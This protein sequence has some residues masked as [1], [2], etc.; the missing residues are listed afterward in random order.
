MSVSELESFSRRDVARRAAET[1]EGRKKIEDMVTWIKELRQIV[2]D[3]PE[4]AKNYRPPRELLAEFYEQLA[5]EYEEIPLTKEEIEREFSAENLSKLPLNDYVKLLRR[6]PARF[7]THVTRQGI[8]DHVSHHYS[9]SEQYSGGFEKIIEAGKLQSVL[10]QYLQGVVTRDVVKQVLSDHLKIPQDFDT[11]EEAREHIDDFLNRSRSNMLVSSEIADQ[12]ALHV[13]MDHVADDFYGG[14]RGNEIFFAY[15]TA[16]VAAHNY[17]APQKTAFRKGLELNAEERSSEYNDFWIRNKKNGA[18]ELPVDAAIVFIPEN[19]AVDPKTGSRYALGPDRKPLPNTDQ[20]EKLKKIIASPEMKVLWPKMY[21]RITDYRNALGK[22]RADE[23][24]L[25]MLRNE[26]AGMY[27]L[28]GAEDDVRRST[29]ELEE[30]MEM[31]KP[32]IDSCR[33]GGLTDKRFYDI[34]ESRDGEAWNA[35]ASA[36]DRSVQSEPFAATPVDD[37]NF[38][39]RVRSLGIYLK[40]AENTVS[41]RTYWEKR[42]Q[43]SGAKRPSKVIFY[44]QAVPTQALQAFKERAGLKDHRERIDLREMFSE[45]LVSN[46]DIHNQMEREREIFAQYAEEILRDLYSK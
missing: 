37:N 43:T 35:L 34:F 40:L 23:D 28:S 31:I 22:K 1:P 41:S 24:R 42:F 45:N 16:Y 44:E 14:E 8:R 17:L 25:A 32:F 3:N 38:T 15:P 19:A 7:V 9:G 18:G 4:Q 27:T 11:V 10:E 20:I 2:R 36:F 6:V 5:R 46:R 12:R 26:K 39:E 21:E 29:A 13:A 30:K 33:A